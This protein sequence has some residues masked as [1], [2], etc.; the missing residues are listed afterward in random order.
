MLLEAGA[1]VNPVRVTRYNG[2]TPIQAAAAANGADGGH[3]TTR[4][5]ITLL[6]DRGAGVNAPASDTAGMTALQAAC[7]TGQTGIVELLLAKGANVNAPAGKF[8]GFTALQAA[9]FCGYAELVDLLLRHGANVNAPGSLVKGGTAL[10]AAVDRGHV[11][12]VKALL[13]AGADPNI[14]NGRHG[15]GTTPR[16]TAFVLGRTEIDELLTQAGATGPFVG[17]Q[18]AFGH[19]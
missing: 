17:G 10:H 13:A 12:I 19:R 5:I 2:R 11:E 7:W 18:I 4:E 1:V 9:A 3:E 6:L 14:G 15:S 16:Q 8:K